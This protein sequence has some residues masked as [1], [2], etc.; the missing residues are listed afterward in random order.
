MQDKSNS[1]SRRNF[2]KSSVVVGAAA[3]SASSIAQAQSANETITVGIMGANGRGTALAKGF[4]DQANCEV[5]YICDVDERAQA[6]GVAAVSSRQAKAPTKVG[7][8]RKI[9]DDDSVDVLVVAAPDH[10]HAPATIRGCAANKHVYVEKPCSHNP[11]EGEMAVAASKKYNKTVNMG[12][13]RR[14]WPAIQEGIKKGHNGEIGEV[15]YSRGWYNNRRGSIG[16]GKVAANPSWLNF[17]LWQGPAPRQEYK[18]NLLHYNWHWFWNWGTGEIGNNGVHAIDVCRWGLEVDYPTQVVS[19]G[20]RLR[21][22]DDQ[23]TPDSHVATFH[24]PGNKMITWEG[25]SW[26]PRGFEATSFGISFHGSEGT[27]IIDGNGYKVYDMKNKLVEEKT[28]P[29][30]DAD[31]LANFLGSIRKGEK[32]NSEIVEAHKSTLLCH[33]GN[34]AQRTSSTLKTNPENGH[35]LENAAAEQLW[36]REYD[37]KWEPKV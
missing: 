37:S 22:D 29:G 14:S 26:H 35:I 1:A 9:L 31:H 16:T 28:G 8:F 33:L 30:G 36:S 17:D 23:Q 5:A 25:I 21:Y 12:N 11:N 20:A 6:K 7:D 3:L 4:A 27:V 10:W 24:F 18:D 15:F 2:I 13:Q 34:I 19:S 32:P